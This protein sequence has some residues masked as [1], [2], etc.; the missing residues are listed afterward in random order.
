MCDNGRSLPTLKSPVQGDN[1]EL[2]DFDVKSPTDAKKPKTKK[3][4][5]RGNEIDIT[6]YIQT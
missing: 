4:S 2:S 3:D 5:Q 6:N 1:A